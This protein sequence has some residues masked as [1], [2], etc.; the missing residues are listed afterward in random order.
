[1]IWYGDACPEPAPRFR[2][3]GDVTPRHGFTPPRG[4]GDERTLEQRPAIGPRAQGPHGQGP[5]PHRKDIA[6][7]GLAMGFGVRVGIG[8]GGRGSG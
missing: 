7:H 2:E 5:E 4:P 3:T 6:L 1:M 8:I